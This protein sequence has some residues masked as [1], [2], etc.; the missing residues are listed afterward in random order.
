MRS[1][2][3][4]RVRRCSGAF[5]PALPCPANFCSRLSAPLI[6]GA[7]RTAMPSP[8]AGGPGI[9]RGGSF[10]SL[11]GSSGR[12]LEAGSVGGPGR[13]H[14]HAGVQGPRRRGLNRRGPA[15]CPTPI[16]RRSNTLRANGNS[17]HLAE[18]Y[19]RSSN[20]HRQLWL[21]SLTGLYPQKWCLNIRPMILWR[22]HAVAHHDAGS[23]TAVETSVL[24]QR[25]QQ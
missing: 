21:P 8:F 20:A 18:K 24:L 22:C 16:A 13:G 25:M 17:L 1:A 5:Q 15:H 11:H 4:L 14:A 7:R 23:S 9:A 2:W 12:S 19:A 10:A 3:Y 6:H